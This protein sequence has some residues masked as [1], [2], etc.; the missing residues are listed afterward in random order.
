MQKIFTT[1]LMTV[2]LGSLPAAVFAQE[3]ASSANYK[4]QSD[5]IN[6]LGGRT[7]SQ[8]FALEGT[9]GEDGAGFSAS[10]N[11]GMNAGY[12]LM[13][14]DIVPPNQV[15]TTTVIDL[16]WNQMEITWADTFDDYG[17]TRYYIYRNGARIADVPAFPRDYVDRKLKAN[18]EYLYNVSAVD[19]AGNEGPRSATTT[20]H[21][22][23]EPLPGGPANPSV[24]DVVL[25]DLEISSN[26]TNVV[27]SFSTFAGYKADV[28]WGADATYSLGRIAHDTFE[29]KHLFLLTGLKP[30]TEYVAKIVL[31]DGATHKTV[32]ENIH[33]RTTYVPLVN[34]PANP[35]NFVA[36]ATDTS[37]DLSWV[38]PED[39]R[40]LS[41][42]LVRSAKSY[43]QSASDGEVIFEGSAEQFSDTDVNV[44]TKYYYTLFSVDQAGNLSSGI[45]ADAMI[46]A[47]GQ[48]A[49][50]TAPFEN[51]QMA[52]TVDPKIAGL[53][54]KDFLFIQSGESLK[55]END[56]VTVDG[57]E[58]L[59][60]ALKTYRLPQVLKT[61]AATFVI[62]ASEGR[63]AQSFTVILRLD[64]AKKRYES[65]IAPLAVAEV[66]GLKLSIIDFKNQGLKKISGKL[67]SLLPAG[68]APMTSETKRFLG[69]TGGAAL[70][71][72]VAWWF[73]RR[74]MISIT[75]V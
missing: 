14:I 56:T 51:I 6:F 69:W 39:V 53:T 63:K 74:K 15:A 52:G 41:V 13:H 32:F 4:I 9:G 38:M 34:L 73:E 36:R 61:I 25:N 58:N 21:T 75:H 24:S 47:P 26:D 30:G 42:K 16:T 50:T 40:I 11:F 62:P 60:I 7:E 33:F 8:N 2:L 29:Q 37:I 65:T 54:M 44:G 45:V 43:P 28:S 23:K 71:A 46:L 22:L 49:T 55:V 27:L 5:S 12:E 68:F 66:F 57:T 72:V 19:E 64:D 59:T 10:A 31:T 1:F 48:N 35:K 3:A 67:I 17:V 70:L 20:V 18:T